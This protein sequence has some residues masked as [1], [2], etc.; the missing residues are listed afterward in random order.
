MMTL[1]LKRPAAG[2]ESASNEHTEN[3]GQECIA[4]ITYQKY[5]DL[6]DRRR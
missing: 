5:L 2:Y 3:P 6:E 1:C 4:K